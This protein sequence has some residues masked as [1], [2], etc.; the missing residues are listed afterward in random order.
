MPRRSDFLSWLY[1]AR[2]L[3]AFVISA[4][5]GLLIWYRTRSARYWPMTYG[6]V[7][8]GMTSDVDGWKSNLSY[9][10]NVS[11]EFYSGV[12]PLKTQNEAAADEEVSKWKGQNLAIRYSP[13]NPSISVVRMEDQASL[14]DGE[15]RGH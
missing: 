9:S 1:L 2:D 5:T 6:K 13:R 10:Y 12:L 4:A 15:F 8:Y 11:G 3:I 14:S 7:E